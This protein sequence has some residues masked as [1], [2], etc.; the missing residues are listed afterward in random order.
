MR[1]SGWGSQ[2]LN[3]LAWYLSNIYFLRIGRFSCVGA[4]GSMGSLVGGSCLAGQWHGLVPD[5]SPGLGTPLL[6]HCC[7][8]EVDIE[9]T[10]AVSGTSD[11]ATSGK[12]AGT[13]PR[14]MQAVRDR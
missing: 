13:N 9:C 2:Q 1:G 12:L 5:L 7:G 6:E 3:A 14:S 11:D 10:A 8:G 4:Q